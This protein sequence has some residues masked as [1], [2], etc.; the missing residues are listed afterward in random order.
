MIYDCPIIV[1][2]SDPPPIDSWRI[3]SQFMGHSPQSNISLLLTIFFLLSIGNFL[4]FP[5]SP[6]LLFHIYIKT[7]QA[8]VIVK[9][10]NKKN[11]MNII[12]HR[13]GIGRSVSE[14]HELFI[15]MQKREKYASFLPR[16]SSPVTRWKL[17]KY[18]MIGKEMCQSAEIHLKLPSE[19]ASTRELLL[20]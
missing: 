6:A 17:E 7:T 3:V 19:Q 12:S 10:N 20:N 2:H 9:G 18:V 13:T 14:R 16:A 5:L 11:D 8:N 4:Y 1:K 15:I